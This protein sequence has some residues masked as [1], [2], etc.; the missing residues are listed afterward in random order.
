MGLK[1]NFKRKTALLKT[2]DLVRA[3]IKVSSAISVDLTID[4]FFSK[5][6]SVE[7]LNRNLKPNNHSNIQQRYLLRLL[8]LKVFLPLD[9]LRSLLLFPPQ[10]VGLD[11]WICLASPCGSFDRYKN[12]N[13]KV[14]QSIRAFLNQPDNL[15]DNYY[16]TFETS[17]GNKQRLRPIDREKSPQFGNYSPLLLFP[18][19]QLPPRVKAKVIEAYGN[20]EEFSSSLDH[21]FLCPDHF[22]PVKDNEPDLTLRSDSIFNYSLE[23]LLEVLDKGQATFRVGRKGWGQLPCL[24]F[25]I[26]R[27]LSNPLF[28]DLKPVCEETLACIKGLLRNMAG[29]LVDLNR[30]FSDENYSSQN[31][32]RLESNNFPG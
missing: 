20:D 16:D 23:Y 5:F 9:T 28:D 32:L 25:L 14:I 26:E 10:G 27:S 13:I 11:Q 4:R 19:K 6:C 2:F 31:N 7:Q 22:G 12:Q 3:H 17:W 21:L 15:P 1:K 30:L 24:P 8:F 18:A 29:N